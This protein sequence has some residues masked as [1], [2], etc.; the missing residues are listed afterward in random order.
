M[1]RRDL[2][3]SGDIMLRAA[4]GQPERI[5][6]YGAVFYDA[7]NPGTE[8]RTEYGDGWVSIERIMPG[9]FDA[10]LARSDDVV[11]LWSHAAT[12]P[13]GRRSKGTLKLSVDTRGLAYEIEPPATTWGRDALES[14]KRGDVI[15][16]SF[17]FAMG[18][19][20]KVIEDRASKSVIYE[21]SRIERLFEVSPVPMPAYPG[22]AAEARD[23]NGAQD[24]VRAA[25][26]RAKQH[27]FQASKARAMVA[28]AL[29]NL[30]TR[31]IK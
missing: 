20:Y 10:A 22:T 9:A 13:L 14:I 15:A 24:E 26:E 11:A 25:I 7:S 4:E 17:G 18:S 21:I 29:A 30:G 5:V 19:G 28:C 12:M 2:Q 1:N 16:S 3:H 23:G 31:E 6:G 8:Y 27:A